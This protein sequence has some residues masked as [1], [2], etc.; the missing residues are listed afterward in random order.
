M[1]TDVWSLGMLLIEFSEGK[2]PVAQTSNFFEVLSNIVDFKLPEL[3][4]INSPEFMN[5]IEIG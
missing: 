5:F 4:N 3:R 2:H 1:K